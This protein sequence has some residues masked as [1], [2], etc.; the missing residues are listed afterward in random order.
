MKL[1][2]RKDYDKFRKYFSFS[3]VDLLIFDDKKIL[4]TKRKIN[5]YKGYWHLPGSIIRRG[6]KIHDTVKRSAMH[7]LGKKI[8]I[9]RELGT[10]E[11][12]DDFRH[13]VSHGFLVKFTENN[14]IE[15]DND[16]SEYRYFSRLPKNMPKHHRKMI[17][18][19][20]RIF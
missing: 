18:D 14:E 17:L 7:E 8:S 1:V 13:D 11:A 19:A 9:K 20:R 5:P 10:Y 12:I 2:P 6:E 3:C 15:I 4:L 16:T